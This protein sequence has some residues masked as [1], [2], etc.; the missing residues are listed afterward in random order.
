VVRSALPC[1]LVLTA[2]IGDPVFVGSQQGGGGGGGGSVA[3]SSA[4]TTGSSST[5]TGEA[6]ATTT[7]P[8]G[9]CGNW[10]VE[11]GE[12]CEDGNTFPG[13]GCS[14]E[15]LLEAFCGNSIVEPGE[16]CDGAE[17]DAGCEPLPTSACAGGIELNFGATDFVAGAPIAPWGVC[18]ST[19]PARFVGWYDTGPL[20]T[21]L[22]VRYLGTSEQYKLGVGC[23]QMPL[24]M[25][26]GTEVTEPLPA[27]SLVWLTAFTPNE[28]DQ[29][30]L[31]V[32]QTRFGSWLNTTNGG[33]LDGGGALSWTWT[34]SGNGYW[35]VTSDSVGQAVLVS[36]PVDLSGLQT[37]TVHFHGIFAEGGGATGTVEYSVDGMTWLVAAVVENGDNDHIEYEL[38]GAEGQA[39]VTV[40]WVFDGQPMASWT[41]QNVFIG[42]PVPT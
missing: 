36:P 25:C 20:P 41:I 38:P 10:L 11:A 31:H 27:H 1:A 6:G 33:L 3:T 32:F 28:G 21:R 7:G 4:T 17:C 26:D 23:Q 24:T 15:C 14:P 40:R 9:E 13:D 22:A 8:M 37:A 29:R 16:K 2:C 19:E 12:E 39:S 5:S 34:S 30:S 42:P 18:S 35:S